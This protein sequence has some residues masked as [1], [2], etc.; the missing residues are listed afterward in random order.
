MY[1]CFVYITPHAESI[2][3]KDFLVW[4][5]QHPELVNADKEGGSEQENAGDDDI[6]I[7]AR[8]SKLP[9]KALSFECDEL[10][11]LNHSG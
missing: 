10:L 1:I 2:Y 5:E 4:L 7:T 3:L 6:D 11:R 8:Y 9:K